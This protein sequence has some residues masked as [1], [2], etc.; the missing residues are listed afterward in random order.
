MIRHDRKPAKRSFYY[1]Q[2]SFIVKEFQAGVNERIC[3]IRRDI[4]NVHKTGKQILDK[5]YKDGVYYMR[6][7][8]KND[9]NRERTYMV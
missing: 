2:C 3:K 1:S 6:N 4:T 7:E 5:V 9:K 8:L